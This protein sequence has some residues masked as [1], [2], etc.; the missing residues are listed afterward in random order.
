MDS[1]IR[2]NDEVW[3][4]G[5]DEAWVVSRPLLHSDGAPRYR[6][7]WIPAFAGMTR[8]LVIPTWIEPKKDRGSPINISERPYLPRI[9]FLVTGRPSISNR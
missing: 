3:V 5:V 1:R 9:I 8:G 4:T 6:R 2:G 7:P